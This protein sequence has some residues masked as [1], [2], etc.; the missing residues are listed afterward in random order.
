MRLV[1]VQDSP[2]WQGHVCGHVC[3]VGGGGGQSVV[4]SG[5]GHFWWWFAACWW[6]S[7][8]ASGADVIGPVLFKTAQGHANPLPPSEV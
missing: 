3:G 6:T 7:L 8:I 1:I 2:R 4:T 5:G